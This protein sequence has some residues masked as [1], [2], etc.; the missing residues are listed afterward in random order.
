M[1]ITAESIHNQIPYY[2]TDDAKISLTAALE[3]FPDNTDYY[4]NPGLSDTL[5]GD[6]W[7]SLQIIE[8]NTMTRQNI[9]G[10]VL[11]NSCDID[12]ENKREVPTK[13]NF[14]PII[15]LNAFRALLNASELNAES[16]EGKLKAI[17]EQRV[18]SV[19]FLPAG[20][21]L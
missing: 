17:S 1:E 6:G 15:K 14:A 4:L 7:N 18:S 10:I 19:F 3:S 16:I 2:L 12:P 11:S 8:F 9:K 20:G 21:E 13:L 5:Q